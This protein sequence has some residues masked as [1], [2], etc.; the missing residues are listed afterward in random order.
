MNLKKFLKLLVCTTVVLLIYIHLQMKIFALGYHTQ[1]TQK[2]IQELM[3]S[4]GRLTYQILA[5][6]SASNI[7]KRILDDKSD[8]QFVEQNNILQL[9][10]QMIPSQKPSV[11]AP[12]K[13]TIKAV[14]KLTKALT[15]FTPQT[16]EAQVLPFKY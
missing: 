5:L 13:N 2:Q 10:T 8:L 12:R 15:W 4:N 11:Q 1:T 16:A 9:T 7:G 6:K 3:D 14:D